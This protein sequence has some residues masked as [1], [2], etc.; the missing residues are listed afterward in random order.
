MMKTHYDIISKGAII[1]YYWPVH[2][3]N[4]AWCKQ[5]QEK[6]QVIRFQLIERFR[7]LHANS[8]FHWRKQTIRKFWA[9]FDGDTEERH[10]HTQDRRRKHH[11]AAAVKTTTAGVAA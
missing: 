3:H 7:I 6:G 10:V 1:E 5:C 2:P 8:F 4:Y 11:G 9:V